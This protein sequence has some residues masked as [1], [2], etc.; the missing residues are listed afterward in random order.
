[1]KYL[2]ASLI[3]A[4]LVTVA[5]LWAA[6]EPGP[7][8]AA[9]TEGKAE[10]A[11]VH[12]RQAFELLPK[13]SQEQEKLL[14]E[15]SSAPIDK[16]T[17]KV[18]RKAEPALKMLRQG[19]QMAHCD[20]GLPKGAE[21]LKALTPAPSDAMELTKAFVLPLNDARSLVRLACL[22]ARY[23]AQQGRE[24]EAVDNLAAALTLGRQLGS[25]GAIVSFIV[26]VAIESLVVDTAARVLPNL[27]PEALT[28]LGKRIDAAPAGATLKTA[29]Q[30]DNERDSI[31]RDFTGDPRYG[32][33]LEFNKKLIE[34]ADLPPD[35]FAKEFK[36]IDNP[37]AASMERAHQIQSAARAKMAML[38]AAIKI[39]LEGKKA[40]ESTK[41]PYGDG[42]FKYTE[43]PGGF[44]LESELR[45]DDKPVTL[46]I[47]NQP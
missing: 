34:I 44:E 13:L 23:S 42:P 17:E 29:L 35:E 1:M 41:D 21:D 4:L 30:K 9:K 24:Q 10:N 16:A 19:A 40:V 7:G 26:Q 45:M 18:L 27:G 25:T 36:K 11:A 15:A 22:Q 28:Q 32:Q 12:Y 3:V 33:M 38:A 6:E 31:L 14:R 8:E 20:W 43:V 37:Q 46:R 2:T 5:P 47:G 39:R